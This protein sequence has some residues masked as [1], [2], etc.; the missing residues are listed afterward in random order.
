MPGSGLS[1]VT[2]A[3]AF[4]GMPLGKSFIRVQPA[5][6][7]YAFE[8]T[9]I[10]ELNERLLAR[11]DSSWDDP[12]PPSA[13][14]DAWPDAVAEIVALLQEE[15]GDARY[16]AIKDSRLARLMPL[17]RPAA[18]RLELDL[19]VALVV[20]HPT[21]V[22][23]SLAERA[24]FSREKSL[25]L[26]FAQNLAAERASRDL[27][28]LIVSFEEFLVDAPLV[29]RRI[30][31]R[32]DLPR[33]IDENAALATIRDFLEIPLSPSVPGNEGLPPEVDALHVCLKRLADSEG[34]NPTAY[35]E[36]DRIAA[37]FEAWRGL[38][39]NREIRL[40]RERET[41]MLVRLAQMTDSRSW[42]FMAPVRRLIDGWRHRLRPSTT[43]SRAASGAKPLAGVVG[44]RGEEAARD[45]GP[46]TLRVLANA[47]VTPLVVD[48]ATM[49]FS[50][51]VHDEAGRLVLEAQRPR[52]RNAWMPADPAHVDS[53][54]EG[55]VIEGRCVYLGHYWDHY[56]HFLIE[57][58]S[59]FWS[60]IEDS[61]Y[62]RLVFHPFVYGIRPL[63]EYA[64]ARTCLAAFGVDPAR[65]LIVDRRLKF[66]DLAVPS[67]L[68]A[69]NRGAAD[70]QAEVFKRIGE[71]CE[72]AG[73]STRAT[74]RPERLYVSRRNWKGASL[75]ENEDEIERIFESFGF[76]VLHPE[77][78][79]FEE[80]V[81]LYRRAEALA[82]L[83]GSA[84][85]NTVFMAHGARAIHLGTRRSPVRVN[86][87]QVFCD[88]LGGVA[89]NFIRFVG[90][91]LGHRALDADHL[92]RELARLL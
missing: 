9:R 59:R 85:H 10:A 31:D 70:G 58:I 76:T 88:R 34:A 90:T 27:P 44:R 86:R 36:L 84:M 24:G 37:D 81:R 14:D 30:A 17:W 4:Q 54:G 13:I 19:C 18:E 72:A 91:G 22:A 8:N 40:P 16:L 26:W 38:F 57:S 23:A 28:R 79:L 60:L 42:R 25:L 64:P 77:R 83:T 7:E 33:L 65:A 12:F 67:P 53:H 50:G 41:A 78:M 80:Q 3:L 69:I 49:T 92:R 62:D 51:S 75:V 15:L 5:G 43:L 82:G 48:R 35:A 2:G 47:I 1:A 29:L 11:L 73:R 20:R 21:A 89:S 74:R 39:L 61:G 46:S 6:D 45:F 66:R 56:G 32:F 87:N 71:Y 52:W 68:V 55:T 63:S